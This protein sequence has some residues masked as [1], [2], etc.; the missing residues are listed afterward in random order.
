MMASLHY[1]KAW[2]HRGLKQ[3]PEAAADYQALLDLPDGGVLR[4][5]A[6]LELSELQADDKKFAEAASRLHEL[7]SLLAGDEKA[8]PELDTQA[9]YR[10]AV[11]EFN[12]NQFDSAAGLFDEFI[13]KAAENEQL[14]ASALMLA[15]E[16]HYKSNRHAEAASRFTRALAAQPDDESAPTALLRLADAHAAL[17]QWPQS[18]SA[19]EKF[20]DQFDNNEQ[21]FAARFAL[22]WALENQGELDDAIDAYRAVVDRH[23]GETAARA[24]FQIGQ[25]LFAQKKFDEAARELVKVDILYAYPAWSAA[26]LY[27]AGRCFRSLNDPVAARRHFEQ[28]VRDHASTEWAPLAQKQLTELASTTLPGHQNSPPPST[29]SN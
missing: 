23:Q 20:L 24:Q 11:C 3:L 1:E 4:Y 6:M 22:G 28:V 27:E 17:K 9:T 21:W 10:L 14:L 7:R 13:D 25:C 8:P 5:Y 16:S 29:R 18:Q 19:A 15:G 26:A 2:C 12:M